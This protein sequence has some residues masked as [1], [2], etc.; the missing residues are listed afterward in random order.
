MDKD[1]ENINSFTVEK[2]FKIKTIDTVRKNRSLLK[3]S[4]I[5]KNFVEDELLNNKFITLH[6]LECLCL[7]YNINLI[8][9]KDNKTYTI[10]S[11]DKDDNEINIDNYK[12][13]RLNYNNSSNISKNFEVIIEDT[14]TD[15]EL[16]AIISSCYYIEKLDKPMKAYTSYKLT[17]LIIIANKLNITICNDNAKSR[18]KSE[19]YEDILK[20]LS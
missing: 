14:M 12:V 5:R 11:S 4:K 7:I 2:E 20:I 19:L 13:I 17:E 16:H 1:L 15:N 8:I 18:K 10:F 3:N 6:T 9:I